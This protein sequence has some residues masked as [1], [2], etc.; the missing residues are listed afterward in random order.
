MNR[1]MRLIYQSLFIMIC[2]AS[3]SHAAPFFESSWQTATGTSQQAVTDGGNWDRLGTND[4]NMIDIQSVS[5]PGLPAELQGLNMVTAYLNGNTGWAMLTKENVGTDTV[6][7]FYWRFYL[8]V[9]TP[10]NISYGMLH[11]WQD[12]ENIDARSMNFYIGVVGVYPDG[13]W[14]PGFWSYAPQT[15]IGASTFGIDNSIA[16][17]KR[18]YLDKWYLIEGHIQYLSR[19]G[20]VARTRYDIR[21]FD[22]L[23]S[24]ETPILTNEEFNALN[25]SGSCYGSTL[26]SHYDAGERWYFRSISTTFGIGNN[27]PATAS[28]QGPLYDMTGFALSHDGWIGPLGGNGGP[29]DPTPLAAPSGLRIR[30]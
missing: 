2:A 20:A 7:D 27:G 4:P 18:L 22:P 12:F 5:G 13:R 25:C 6:D 3:L 23:I 26:K 21:F 11:A 19:D 15:E 17:N 28:G 24:T 9:K 10:T 8:R 30:Q 29:S 14:S 1:L 16:P